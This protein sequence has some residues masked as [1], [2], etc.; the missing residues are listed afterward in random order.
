MA[1]KGEGFPHLERPSGAQIRGDQTQRF[2]CPIGQ[3]SLPSSQAG[4]Y[5]IRG[6]LWAGFV[7]GV[8]EGGQERT[9]EAGRRGPPV[10]EEGER[11]GER[12]PFPIGHW[13]PAELEG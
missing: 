7:L 3:G 6:P 1:E 9:G 5:A 10:P 11:S 13:E 12:L 4:S 8:K 2:P